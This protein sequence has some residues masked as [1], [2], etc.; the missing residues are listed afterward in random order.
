MLSP[1]LRSV[2]IKA[3]LPYLKG[4]VLDYG[5]GAGALAE[6]VS[7]HDYLGVDI[8]DE[9]LRLARSRFPTHRFTPALTS[10]DGLF[11]SIISL[12]VIEHTRDP[13]DFLRCLA[14]HIG[15]TADA[16]LVL[17]TPHPA[18]DWVH[19]VG[20]FLRLFSRHANEE[21]ETLLDHERLEIVG[22]QAGL[23]MVVYRRFLFG[24]NQLAVYKK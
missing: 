4:R 7:A 24:A 3:A 18:V 21:H 5:C 15:E 12:A 1:W 19:D 17:T 6:H 11:D 14:W 16:R 20:A 22:A 13:V 10:Q 23:S 2:R 8:D 9:S